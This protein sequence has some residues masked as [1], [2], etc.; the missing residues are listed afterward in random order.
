LSGVEPQRPVRDRW[1]ALHPAARAL[2]VTVAAII[3]V[4]VGLNVL[5]T[6]TR[7]AE[8]SGPDSSSLST[9][10][11]GLAAYEELLARY[12]HAI[13]H[14]RGA[15][16]DARLD[17]A[18]TLVVLDPGEINRK[19]L[20]NI[21]R[22]LLEGG[23]LVAGGNRPEWLLEIAPADIP[24]WTPAGDR[25]T[26]VALRDDGPALTVETSGSGSW[27]LA[28][29]RRSLTFEP[30]G[31]GR[32]VLLADA[33][34][35][36]NRLLGRADNA[37]FGLSL[38][39]ES[40]RPVVFAEG[41][42]GYGTSTGLAAIPFR[43]KV[44]LIA[45]ALAALLAMVAAGRRLGPP[46]D[47]TRNL[48]PP[49]RVYV[50]AMAATLART[51]R[52]AD[53]LAPLQRT[54]QAQVVQRAGLEPHASPSTIGDAARALGWPAEEVEAMFVPLDTDARILAAGRALLRARGPVRWPSEMTGLR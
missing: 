30:G 1:R 6:A 38:A 10:R 5:D 32:T 31:P 35:L 9:A 21:R 39:G 27:V 54:V 25:T 24:G 43:W 2:V 4:G 20:D 53:A 29:G 40:S 52:P 36:H 19:D 14:Q 41:V 46:E 51:R 16:A 12:G 49:R 26:A 11:T 37:A 48:A 7:G 13:G 44:A 45:V 28:G 8:P 15:L 17:P 22:F 42:H 47:A 3:V 23:R 33:S 18:S 50:D 34:P